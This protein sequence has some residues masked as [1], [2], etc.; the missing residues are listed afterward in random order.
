MKESE[1]L[2]SGYS[3]SDGQD[4]KEAKREAETIEYI[5]ANT[6]LNNLDKTLKI[7]HKLVEKQTFKT[8]VGYEFLRKLQDD[9]RKSEVAGKE[10]LQNIRIEKKKE[11]SG[12]LTATA[13]TQNPDHKFQSLYE[14]Y[15]IRHRNSRIINIFLFAIITAMIIITLISDRTVYKNYKNDVLNQYATWEEELDAREKALEVRESAVTVKED[16]E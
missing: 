1:N 13:T 6:D 10:D 12:K 4:Y 9:L 3:F 2:V 8:V 5:K 7:Y 14:E 15:R 11:G 16:K